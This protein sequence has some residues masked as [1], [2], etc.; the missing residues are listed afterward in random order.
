LLIPKRF[1][2]LF[3]TTFEEEKSACSEGVIDDYESAIL[4]SYFQW[5]KITHYFLAKFSDGKL[6]EDQK[7]KSDLHSFIIAQAVDT[8]IGKSE[9]QWFERTYK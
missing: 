5:Q 9:L 3:T 2:G 8:R 6:N 1:G 4:K 7:L